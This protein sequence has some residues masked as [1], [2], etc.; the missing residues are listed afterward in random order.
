MPTRKFAP[1]TRYD[2]VL[3]VV[4][5]EV[6]N[7]TKS[8]KNAIRLTLETQMQSADPEKTWHIAYFYSLSTFL[9]IFNWTKSNC[10]CSPLFFP[11]DL[12]ISKLAK[13]SCLLLIKWILNYK[14]N[15]S[16]LT[17]LSLKQ[18]KD[19]LTIAYA[20]MRDFINPMYM[21]Y[22]YEAAQTPQN[23]ILKG[24]LMKVGQHLNNTAM[25]LRHK[26]R[27]LNNISINNHGG[28]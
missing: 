24:V 2:L 18:R 3:F 6:I 14:N 7:V 13:F 5:D 23:K 11:Q 19:N 26:V 1:Q 20:K 15:Y 8:K 28:D 12:Q 9:E 22:S 25:R 16:L 10:L 4:Y 21:A 27:V 17:L